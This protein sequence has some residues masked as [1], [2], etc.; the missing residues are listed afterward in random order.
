M[1][2]TAVESAAAHGHFMVAKQ[3]SSEK[4]QALRQW[5]QEN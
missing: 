5:K 1:D 2:S 3:L 4:Q